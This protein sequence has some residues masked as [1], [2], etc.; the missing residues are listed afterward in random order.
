[1]AISFSEDLYCANLPLLPTPKNGSSELLGLAW[2]VSNY[3]IWQETETPPSWL[4]LWPTPSRKTE[5]GNEKRL[6]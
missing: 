3:D 1:M 2:N 6:I 4:K 5:R